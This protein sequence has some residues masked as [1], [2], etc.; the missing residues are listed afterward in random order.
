VEPFKNDSKAPRDPASVI[1]EM[2]QGLT[3]EEQQWLDRLIRDHGMEWVARH[4]KLLEDQ[5]EYI[6]SM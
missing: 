6:R 4:R 5:L 2:R 3:A 1:E